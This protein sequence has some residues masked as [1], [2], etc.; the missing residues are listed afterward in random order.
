ML[1]SFGEMA[2][3]LSVHNVRPDFVSA[4][5]RTGEELCAL[6]LSTKGHTILQRQ[7]SLTY[8]LAARFSVGQ[9]LDTFSAV[10]AVLHGVFRA[11]FE[12]CIVLNVA[13]NSPNGYINCEGFQE[14]PLRVAR[15]LALEAV[16]IWNSYLWTRQIANI[17][18]FAATAWDNKILSA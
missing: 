13:A 18:S 12:I 3:K 15:Q 4:N 14:C 1:I 7:Q 11:M 2:P 5:R 6:P 8:G 9:K 17:V 16:T 10:A